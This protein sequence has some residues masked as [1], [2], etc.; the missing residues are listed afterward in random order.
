MNWFALTK[1]IEVDSRFVHLRFANQTYI[2]H[3]K[4][5]LHYSWLSFKASFYF[6]I[7][8]IYPD[9]FHHNGS[10]AITTINDEILEKYS[11]IN[12]H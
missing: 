6:F 12:R 11:N 9:V 2:E 8:A 3:M 5:S 4:D 10:D 1:L 7:H